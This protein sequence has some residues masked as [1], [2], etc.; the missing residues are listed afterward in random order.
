M[1][2]NYEQ[3]CSNIKSLFYFGL[4]LLISI[5]LTACVQQG[6]SDLTS[7]E[8]VHSEI[9][10]V[11]KTEMAKEKT[12]YLDKNKAEKSNE[13]INHFET[14]PEDFFNLQ[15]NII[16]NVL[17]VNKEYDDEVFELI[18]RGKYDLNKDG[19]LDSIEARLKYRDESFLR[20]NNTEFLMTSDNPCDMYLIDLVEDD[21]FIEI[22]VYDDGPS[23]DPVSTFYRYDGK[24]I[25]ELGHFHTHIDTEDTIYSYYGNVLTDGKGNF[26]PPDCIEKFI[27]PNIITGY[28]SIEAQ[29]LVYHPIDYE[30]YLVDEYTIAEDFGA[31]FHEEDVYENFNDEELYLTWDSEQIRQFSKGE[32][33][34]IIVFGDYWY[35]IEREDGTRGILYFWTGD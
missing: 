9:E 2:R 21:S 26:L 14:N 33:T 23:G 4:F 3:V 17:E 28:Y 31:Y 5:G 29:Q 22:V 8:V 30:K 25:Y 20:I 13:E 11:E 10:V 7:D 27:L 34:K 32:K 15:E 19:S 12:E 35:G 16:R 1:R 6:A 18:V 24:N